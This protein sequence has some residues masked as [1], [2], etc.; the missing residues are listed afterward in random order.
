M[1]Q[2]KGTMIALTAIHSGN[3]TVTMTRHGST[4][5]IRNRI[6]GIPSQVFVDLGANVDTATITITD[7]IGA[8][9]E[10]VV[11][12]G[13]TAASNHTRNFGELTGTAAVGRLS[14]VLTNIGGGGTAVTVTVY[15][16]Q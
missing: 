12:S 1:S 13:V 15:I 6:A 10:Q 7:E 11:L 9:V 8:E 14:S 5:T 3:S 4:A 2:I 16:R